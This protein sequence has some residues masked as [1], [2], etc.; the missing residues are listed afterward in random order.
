MLRSRLAKTGE[1]AHLKRLEAEA[2]A[3]VHAAVAA[4]KRAPFP[5]FKAMLATNW[6]GEYAAVADRFI[7][8]TAA[9]FEGRQS[10]ARPGPF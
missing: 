5:D 8:D 2:E 4:A 3:Q 1:E 7:A 6:S 10:E 9:S